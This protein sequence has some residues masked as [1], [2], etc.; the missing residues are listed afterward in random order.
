ML[1]NVREC[2][3][4][5]GLSE[6]H[7]AKVMSHQSGDHDTKDKSQQSGGSHWLVVVGTWLI[8][9]VKAVLK[10]W[11][12]Q[13]VEDKAEAATVKDKMLEG[14]VRFR[15]KDFSRQNSME[16]DKAAGLATRVIDRLRPTL[17]N[18]T[19]TELAAEPFLAIL[20]QEIELAGIRIESWATLAC[21]SS[22]G[23]FDPGLAV[24]TEF[25]NRDG[26]KSHQSTMIYAFQTAFVFTKVVPVHGLR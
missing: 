9:P 11:W 17:P 1:G 5:V 25:T 3:H 6:Q 23:K 24:T 16:E 18:Y 8:A 22:L 21:L 20:E 4:G 2:V 14:I 19:A 7:K 13:L 10:P 15:V 26:S 12:K